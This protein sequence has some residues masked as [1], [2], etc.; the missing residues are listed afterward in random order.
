MNEDGGAV[1]DRV[2][3]V[4]GAE[5]APSLSVTK[6]ALDHVAVSVIGD[7]ESDGPAGRRSYFILAGYASASA[8]VSA[9][10]QHG[11]WLPPFRGRWM[12]LQVRR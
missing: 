10:Y 11:S 4:A 1:G 8:E 3:V 7:V 9:G 5:A 12:W 6:A 2:F